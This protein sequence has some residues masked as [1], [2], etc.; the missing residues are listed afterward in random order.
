MF[1]KVASGLLLREIFNHSFASNVKPAHI[2]LGSYISSL[3]AISRGARYHSTE[4]VL[5]NYNQPLEQREII[6]KKGNLLAT[7]SPG[8][9]LTSAEDKPKALIWPDTIYSEISKDGRV[10]IHDAEVKENVTRYAEEQL[11]CTAIWGVGLRSRSTGQIFKFER[12]GRWAG[13]P[14]EAANLLL[15]ASRNDLEHQD[16][17]PI[18]DIEIILP[19]FG[20]G[21]A[22]LVIPILASLS[23]FFMRQLV[24]FGGFSHH[25]D[26][27]MFAQTTL[28]RKIFSNVINATQAFYP[29]TGNVAAHNI[30]SYRAMID[31]YTH[32]TV[33]GITSLNKVADEHHIIEGDM[34]GVNTGVAVANALE[35]WF[36]A[37][38]LQYRILAIEQFNE[39]IHQLHRE[40][41]AMLR[42]AYLYGV[43]A[44]A[45]A[46]I[47]SNKGHDGKMNF[48]EIDIIIHDFAKACEQYDIAVFRLG[49]PPVIG[50]GT[51]NIALS[52]GPTKLQRQEN[53][54]WTMYNSPRPLEKELQIYAP[55]GSQVSHYR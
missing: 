53:G 51:N 50:H 41:F 6:D 24:F 39:D 9:Q 54:S 44:I 14:Q 26:I 38:C 22:S 20:K 43:K 35:P 46:A 7:Y 17:T 40:L 30:E 49:T 15:S 37:K 10:F 16:G 32:V 55:N 11:G 48:A 3:V 27:A 23:S 21:G 19:L 52:W 8:P 18:N 28:G 1:S 36:L 34:L 25:A 13:T 33:E 2:R 4:A 42:I 5:A 47:Y 12:R 45:V 31:G 29:A